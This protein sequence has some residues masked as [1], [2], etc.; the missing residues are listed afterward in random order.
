MPGGNELVSL[1][2][3]AGSDDAK[4]AVRKDKPNFLFSV[5]DRH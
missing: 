4:L 2:N 3:H 5:K 1:P